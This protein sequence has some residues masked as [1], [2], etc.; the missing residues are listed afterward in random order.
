MSAIRNNS[1]IVRFYNVF[2]ATP[3]IVGVVAALSLI[4]LF[5]LFELLFDRYQLLWSSVEQTDV[6]RNFRITFIHC[7]LVSYSLTAYVYVIQT[8]RH[9]LS[10]LRLIQ[11]IHPG[12]R[13]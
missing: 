1:V 3:I 8:S 12:Q 9:S 2:P 13:R 10:D 7:L 6:Q 5:L 4:V 11:T